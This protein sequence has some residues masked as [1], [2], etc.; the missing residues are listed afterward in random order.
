MLYNQLLHALCEGEPRLTICICHFSAQNVT[1]FES[2]HMVSMLLGQVLPLPFACGDARDASPCARKS[3]HIRICE[4]G[5]SHCQAE[6]KFGIPARTAL[7][8]RH[9]Y[10]CNGI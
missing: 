10:V 1:D 6:R 8:R 9:I 7:Y 4:H 3:V 5:D 2:H